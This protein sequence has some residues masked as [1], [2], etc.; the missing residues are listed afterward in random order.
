MP[1]VEMLNFSIVVFLET[2]LAPSQRPWVRSSPRAFYN[3]EEIICRRVLELLESKELVSYALISRRGVRCTGELVQH[4][5]RDRVVPVAELFV[6]VRTEGGE[7]SAKLCTSDWTQLSSQIQQL[8][9]AARIGQAWGMYKAP[10][11]AKA[12]TTPGSLAVNSP[13]DPF[14]SLSTARR[15]E[16]MSAFIT[17]FEKAHASSQLKLRYYAQSLQ[18]RFYH[19]PDLV[20]ER[21]QS[22]SAIKAQLY[23]Q[24]TTICLPPQLSFVGAQTLLQPDFTLTTQRLKGLLASSQS[25]T[26]Q[27]GFGLIMGSWACAVLLH[28]SLHMGAG[29]LQLAPNFALRPHPCFA[30]ECQT[31]CP[32]QS[33]GLQSTQS[34][35]DSAQFIK[36]LPSK[37]I[38]VDAP[39]Q[40][41][42]I[43]DDCLEV[44]FGVA[45]FVKSDE[46]MEVI[47]PQ[48]Y[49]F[50]P[51]ELWTKLYLSCTEG[52]DDIAIACTHQPW[53]LPWSLVHSPQCYF[54]MVLREAELLS[55]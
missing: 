10:T 41:L 25:S 35:S 38:F 37:V 27:R 40:V 30:A 8:V 24:N 9:A 45:C 17:T 47:P 7:A 55:H 53:E 50:T 42:R 52:Q 15:S 1:I 29:T 22:M 11:P 21:H 26:Q 23:V 43:S 28:E 20:E 2:H 4:E 34:V 18:E 46:N 32:C 31:S 49:R 13:S 54:N 5:A 39:T 48:A 14:W 51:S 33:T 12:Q 3:M 19:S 6:I 16:A 36:L 44:R